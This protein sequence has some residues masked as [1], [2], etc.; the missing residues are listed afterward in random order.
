M[1]VSDETKRRAAAALLPLL[2]SKSFEDAR[3]ID[4]KLVAEV[5]TDLLA[6]PLHGPVN[7][8]VQK[9]ERAKARDKAQTPFV[10]DFEKRTGVGPNASPE[11]KQRAYYRFNDEL[12]QMRDPG[13]EIHRGPPEVS[14]L[15]GKFFPR[16]KEEE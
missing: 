2:E 14:G 8:N 12:R 10:S 7:E 6:G 1:G 3:P 5:L 15:P 11:E 13:V 9:F 4:V 16:K